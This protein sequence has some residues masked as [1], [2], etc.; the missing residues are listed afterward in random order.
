ME[1]Y[2]AREGGSRSKLNS[3]LESLSV[4]V[5][6]NLLPSLVELIAGLVFEVLAV[7]GRRVD[8]EREAAPSGKLGTRRRHG[9]HQAQ[10]KIENSLQGIRRNRNIVAQ[11]LPG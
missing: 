11:T 9:S 4:A 10:E 1:R 5:A 6:E 8:R 2:S 7:G 3:L